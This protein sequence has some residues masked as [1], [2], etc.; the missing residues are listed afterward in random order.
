[1]DIF[2]GEPPTNP[3]ESYCMSVLTVTFETGGRGQDITF[4]RMT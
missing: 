1:M 3:L 4:K 2:L